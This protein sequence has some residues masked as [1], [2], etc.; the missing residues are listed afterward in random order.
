MTKTKPLYWVPDFMHVDWDRPHLGGYLKGG[1]P[2]SW[3]PEMWSWML[4]KYDIRSVIDIGCGEGQAMRWFA[5]RGCGVLGIDGIEQED[6]RIIC[7]DYTKGPILANPVQGR[8]SR[9]RT[10]RAH[11]WADLAWCCEFVEHVEA[12]FEENFLVTFECAKMV[13]MTHGLPG[14]GGH[15]HVNCQPPEYWVQRLADH[16]FRL[17]RPAT[18]RAHE[19]TP[20]GYFDWSGLIFVR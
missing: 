15:H 14:Q 8:V 1:D 5:D 18:R 11:P 9:G 3:Y 2:G 19:L 13:A 16:G 4:K 7:H 10:I 6:K 17:N 12:E 20:N